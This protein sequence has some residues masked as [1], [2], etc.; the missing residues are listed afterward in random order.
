[1][2]LEDRIVGS[3]VGSFSFFQDGTQ[4]NR[5]ILLSVVQTEHNSE[6]GKDSHR[7]STHA[8]DHSRGDR[9]H[10]TSQD[11]VGIV[12][13]VSGVRVVG[14]TS[15]STTRRRR[16]VTRAR[17]SRSLIGRRRILRQL[18]RSS[19]GT[20]RRNSSQTDGL[21]KGSR[22]NQRGFRRLLIRSSRER[23]ERNSTQRVLLHLAHNLTTS[24]ISRINREHNHV[25]TVLHH[26]NELLVHSHL[27]INQGSLRNNLTLVA[28]NITLN[29]TVQAKRV[30]LLAHSTIQEATMV[31]PRQSRESRIGHDGLS[32]RHKVLILEGDELVA[33][34]RQGH[35]FVVVSHV[36]TTEDRMEG[37]IQ[38]SSSHITQDHKIRVQGAIGKL[39]DLEES[40]SLTTTNS[41][42]STSDRLN[43]DRTN[44]ISDDKV[45]HQII[46]RIRSHHKVGT[47]SVG[48]T[49]VETRA[50][51]ARLTTSETFAHTITIQSDARVQDAREL[52]IDATISSTFV[53]ESTSILILTKNSGRDTHSILTRVSGA[54]IVVLTF[55]LRIRNEATTRDR[56]ADRHLASIGA[57]R[58]HGSATS[59]TSTFNTNR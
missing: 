5:R 35:Q 55:T 8:T 34:T 19:S 43:S 7:T 21:I 54:R 44:R 25:L 2:S 47:I 13:R 22:G 27:Q 11:I 32:G 16:Q 49:Q 6:D 45:I 36:R 33:I 31:V 15:C 20:R 3:Q 12:T 39:G 48:H 14:H 40:T 23:K 10:T 50:P 51:A 18:R 57:L 56:V 24:G 1:L 53:V 52:F 41:V 4:R 38:T 42:H 28:N 26:T 37:K 46:V 17:S 59:G 58:A 30:D 29:G 9:G